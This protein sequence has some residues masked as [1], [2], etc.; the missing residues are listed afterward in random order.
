MLLHTTNVLG[1]HGG[2]V[3]GIVKIWM[4]WLAKSSRFF[5][6]VVGNAMMGKQVER[7]VFL[8]TKGQMNS[9]LL[10]FYSSSSRFVFSN[11]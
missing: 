5:L 11:G 4:G 3:G 2:V 9:E 10:D 1:T 6:F 8:S 7:T